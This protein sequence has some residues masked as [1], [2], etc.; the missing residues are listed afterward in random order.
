MIYCILGQT[1]SGKTS[2]ALK[3][4]REFHVPIISADAYQCYKIMQVGTDKPS[5]EEVKDL[6][7]YFYDEYEPDEEVS[8]YDFQQECRPII[9]RCLKEDRD[10]IVVGGNF[11]YVKAL[12]FNYVFQ[13]EDEKRASPYETMSLQEMQ[14]ILKER[15]LETYN[16]IDHQNPRR[17]IRALIQL[18]EGTSHQDIK[19]KNDGK[20]IYPVKFYRLEIDKEEGNKKIDTRIDQMVKQGLI[21]EV[22]SLY[23]RYPKNSRPFTTIGYIEII[24]AIQAGKKVD[25]NIIDL[26]KIHTHQYAKKQRTFL[27]HQFEDIQSGSKDEIYEIL[28]NELEKH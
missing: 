2:L 21:Q 20:P 15:S 23:E 26:I 11:L 16:A 22:T 25:Q 4:A 12:L 1:A 13:K 10:L 6:E 17:V 3:M 7:Y 9:E 19:E 14:N 5:T 18:D 24:Q 28:K 8:V 27:R